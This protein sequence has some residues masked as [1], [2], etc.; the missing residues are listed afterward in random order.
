MLL[1]LS[2]ALADAC[3]DDTVTLSGHLVRW[4]DDADTGRFGLDVRPSLV[5]RPLENAALGPR[6]GVIIAVHADRIEVDGRTVDPEW[7]VVAIQQN[8]SIRWG[9]E[10]NDPRYLHVLLAVD[11]DAP[12][13][14]VVE[15]IDAVRRAHLSTVRV[16]F[17]T[18]PEVDLA[19]TPPRSAARSSVE[20]MLAATGSGRV[21]L[22]VELMTGFVDQCPEIA[23]VLSGLAGE[24][25]ERRP[26]FLA[27]R[28]PVAVV[29]CNC[30]ASPVDL[31]DV[32]WGME[33]GRVYGVDVKVG[34]GVAVQHSADVP[35]REA[36]T[37]VLAARDGVIP[38]FPMPR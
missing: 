37:S 4:A 3:V 17:A 28:L 23:T 15:A 33:G 2:A 13:K 30:A 11:A 24:Y 32:L 1:L 22:G 10:R 5:V 25:P 16:V 26:R 9:A 38:G 29:A 20:R 6:E 36:W 12:W 18:P 7:A 8:S 31:A 19:L 21:E 14:R 34:S 35:W 27:E